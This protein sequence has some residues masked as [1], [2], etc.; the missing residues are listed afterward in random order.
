MLLQILKKITLVSAI[1]GAAFCSALPLTVE[2]QTAPAPAAAAAP[3]AEAP[4]EVSETL[5]S[6]I[7]HVHPVVL[8]CLLA[9]SVLMIWFGVDGVIKT[10]KSRAIPIAQLAQFRELFKAGD[11]VAAYNYAKGNFSPLSDVVKAGVSYL[12][13]GK[14]MTEEAMFGEIARVNG[15]LMGRVSYLSVVGVCAPMVGLCGTV[16]GMMNAF[17]ALSKSGGDPGALSAAIG[18]V[19][20]ATAMGLLLAIPAF[21][22]YYVLRNR[23]TVILHDV[24]EVAAS[25]F[26]KMPYEDFGG[27]HLTD[28]E[29]YAA[30]PNWVVPSSE[31]TPVLPEAE[32]QQEQPAA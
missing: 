9:G 11:Y 4:K 13:E 3:A 27:Y 30:T 1:A 32:Q 5:W 6:K 17:A 15:A 22:L 12:P 19:L 14:E 24:Q 2:A 31:A 16:F 29:I 8:V 10:T 25:L 20:V 7:Q 21:V 18:E 26:R 23:I 28:E